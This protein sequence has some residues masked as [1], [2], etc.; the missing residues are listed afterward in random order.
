MFAKLV[1]NHHLHLVTHFNDSGLEQINQEFCAFQQAL[2]EEVEF[3]EAIKLTENDAVSMD[4][5][6][7]WLPTNNCF[8]WLQSFCGGLA[9][10]FS[11]TATVESYFSIIGFGKSDDRHDLRDFSLEGIL[12]AKQYNDVK[13]LAKDLH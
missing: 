13:K 5:K 6:L 4:F 11:N 3:K 10:A 1:Q 7:L 8:P 12:H 2:H 9:S